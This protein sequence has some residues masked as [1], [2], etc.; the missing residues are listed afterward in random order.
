MYDV[1]VIGGGPAGLAAAIGSASEGLR[2][3]VLCE[4]VGGQAGTSSLIE[5]FLGFPNGI[6]GPDLTAAAKAQAEKFGAE[7]KACV[8]HELDEEGGLFRLRTADGETLVARSVV[9]AS[10]A[11]YRRLDPSTGFEPFEGKGVHYAAT[12]DSVNK[13]CR[14]DR[15]V[16]VGGGNSAGQAAMFLAGKAKQVHL[17]VRK[18]NIRE[19]MSGYLIDRIYEQDNI[20]LHFEAEL[21]KLHG[22]D[23]VEAVT[24]IHKDGSRTELDVTDVYV[25]IGAEP[26]A[27]FARDACATDEHGFIQTDDFYQTKLPGLFAVGDV[28]AGSVK[29]VANAVG[30]G[31]SV[32]KWLWRYLFPPLPVE[33]GEAVA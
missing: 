16:V 10:G 22:D 19:T 4:T 17:V 14:C 11:K 31:S 7:F 24:L 2:T 26:H 23:W 30:E 25:M 15:V 3:V 20:T 27:A 8:C 21:E 32:V 6:S 12:Q 1:A 18:D 29:R 33:P 13:D 9:I 28:R 5:N